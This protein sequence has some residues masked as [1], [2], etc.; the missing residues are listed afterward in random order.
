MAGPTDEQLRAFAKR[1]RTSI[2]PSYGALYRDITTPRDATNATRVYDL[3]T[4]DDI[5]RRASE[6]EPTDSGLPKLASPGS[7]S[8]APPPVVAV[9]PHP[10]GMGMVRQPSLEEQAAQMR[11][12]MD[13][14]RAALPSRPVAV[15]AALDSPTYSIIRQNPYE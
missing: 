2:R 13:A 14:E 6:E 10:M 3:G 7:P 4:V 1:L 9:Q 12:Q 15:Q 5:R 8:P 11:A